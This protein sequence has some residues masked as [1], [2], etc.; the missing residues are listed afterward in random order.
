MQPMVSIVG[1]ANSGKTSLLRNLIA[2]L[3]KRG[4]SI[5]VIKHAGED[6]E[7]DTD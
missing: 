2:E 4:L 6:F 1:R 3:K 7:I 5:A